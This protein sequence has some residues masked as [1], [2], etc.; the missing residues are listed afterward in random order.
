MLEGRLGD[1]PP[2]WRTWSSSW[3]VFRWCWSRLRTVSA[4]MLSCGCRTWEGQRRRRSRVLERFAA[5]GRPAVSFDAVC[6][7]R[8]GSGETWAFAADVLAAFRRR[9][10]PIL[11]QTTLEAMRVITWAQG[12]VGRGARALA[13]GI[14][15]GGDV[16]VGLAGI[17]DRVRRVATIGSTPTSSRPD[18]RELHDSSTVIDQGKA[19]PTPSGSLTSLIRAAISSASGVALRSP[20]SSASQTI[21]CP[22]RMRASS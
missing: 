3:T 17:D 1:T 14:S 21:T 8:R 20:S 5:A 11:G 2:R 4:A 19:D 6:H 18:M 9:M 16:A 22:A 12:Q 15:M 10:W 7:G 13:G